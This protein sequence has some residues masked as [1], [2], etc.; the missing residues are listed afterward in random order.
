M[1]SR[2]YRRVLLALKRRF[3][4]ERRDEITARWLHKAKLLTADAEE[5]SPVDLDD[6]T[7]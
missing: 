3:S 4:H 2:L 5:M 6:S 1:I 7:D